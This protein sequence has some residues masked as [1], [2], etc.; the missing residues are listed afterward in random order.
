[1]LRR[2]VVVGCA[3]GLLT[4]PISKPTRADPVV[5]AIAAASAV[6]VIESI[7]LDTP[8]EDEQDFI[9]VEAGRFDPYR[10]IKQSEEFGAE[11][12]SGFF[13]WKFKPYAGVG[14]TTNGT[15][16]GYAG[17]RLDTY[18]FDRKFIVTPSFALVAY[19]RGD[20]KYLGSPIL[21]RS[22]FDFQYRFDGDYRIGVAFHHMSQ[23]KVFNSRLNPGAE[24]VGMT[25]SMPVTKLIG[26]QSR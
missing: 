10:Q 16:Y 8:Q 21:G 6:L 9:S 17:I 20:G 12:R 23:G 15:F 22:G 14:A 13:L 7:F 4:C 25:F 3:L 26:S 5:N 2:L 11:Y 1:M 18:W 19:D 24:E